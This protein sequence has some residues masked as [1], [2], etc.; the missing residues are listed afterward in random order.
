MGGG[1]AWFKTYLDR[2][3][4]GSIGKLRALVY[5]V[6]KLNVSAKSGAA[7]RQQKECRHSV[8]LVVY[9]GQ[10][11]VELSDTSVIAQSDNP[12]KFW[13]SASSPPVKV[14]D[15]SNQDGQSCSPGVKNG[16]LAFYI[17]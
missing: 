3:D 12:Y 1:G 15:T 10:V 13:R 17:F 16:N 6:L 7:V 2:S 8:K 4:R 9:L 5:S 14:S 11:Y